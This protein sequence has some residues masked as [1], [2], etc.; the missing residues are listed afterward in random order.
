MVRDNPAAV[1]TGEDPVPAALPFAQAVPEH[2]NTL[3]HLD[4]GGQL[5]RALIGMDYAVFAIQKRAY[6]LYRNVG[7]VGFPTTPPAH[8]KPAGRLEAPL[9]TPGV[10]GTPT[11]PSAKRRKSLSKTAKARRGIQ[12]LLG[13][14]ASK[15]RSASK[16]AIA[17]NAQ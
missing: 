17:P 13:G 3:R 12:L 6:G 4:T 16:W 5:Q 15:G 7:K 10:V 8:G 11:P 9:R 2:P 14:D 1:R